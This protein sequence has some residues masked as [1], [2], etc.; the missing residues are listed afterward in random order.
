MIF[1]PRLTAPFA[2]L[3]L[4]ATVSLAQ[5]QSATLAWDANKEPDVT[6]YNLFY[7]TSTQNYSVKL[8]V[9]KTTSYTV[10]GLDL[11]LDY[12]FAVQAY[13]SSGLTSGLSTEVKLPAPVPPGSTKITSF[14]SNAAYPL[15][16]GKTVTWAASATSVRGPVEYKFV[17][18]SAA[19]GWVVAQDYSPLSTFTWTPGFGDL[20]DHNLQV[21]ARAVGS[22]ALYEAWVGS[23][24][25]RVNAAPVAITADVDFPI[26]PG[27]PVRW[28]AEIAGAGS[29]PLEYRFVLLNV[30]T[31]V[32]SQLR[33]YC[34]RNS[35]TW[36]P[37]AGTYIM[38][39]WARR[40]GSTVTYDVWGATPALRVAASPLEVTRLDADTAFP[41]QTGSPITWTARVK[42]GTAGPI[43][44]QFVRYSTKKGWEI[45]RPYSPGS[46]FTWT[47]AWGDE[48]RYAMQVWA[49]NAGST[50]IYDA[51]LGSAFFEIQGAKIHLSSNAVFPVPPGTAVQ[52]TA[53]VA[54]PSLTFEYQFW[55]YSQ[56]TGTWTLARPYSTTKTFSW[57]PALPDTYVVQAWARRTGTAAA[58]DL[59][60]G[61]NYLGVGSTPAKL[62]SLTPSVSLPGKVGTPVTWTAVASGGT[63]APLQYKFLLWNE[64]HGWTLLRDFAAGNTLAWTPSSAQAG[65]NAIQVWV[66]SAGSTAQYES[67]IGSGYFI[68]QP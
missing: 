12:F 62:L 63:A 52:W 57:T 44:Y 3:F 28:T 20:G 24:A 30:G 21:W 42:G 61:T 25:F 58:Y 37:A 5:A 64:V 32:W 54:D 51:W 47:P 4:I 14:T 68:I 35:T 8:N 13:S 66:R 27:Q 31:G 6:G 45:V 40:V 49:R 56:S 53:D 55:V 41:A 50:A 29:S 65:Q 39:V 15:L 19:S 22:P 33:G 23:P 16:A 67:W 46:S 38:Q 7:G 59:A 1:R 2:A 60:A 17:R 26:A 48:D 43:Q 10:T 9:G 36:T 11:S 34:T 18:Y